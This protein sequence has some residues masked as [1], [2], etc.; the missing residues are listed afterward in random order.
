MQV[1]LIKRGAD[2]KTEVEAGK[3]Y[4]TEKPKVETK[5]KYVAEWHHKFIDKYIRSVIYK[6]KFTE[7]VKRK[8]AS[9][10][11]LDVE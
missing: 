5:I 10:K 8:Y 6:D 4:L 2:A 3:K 9:G 1:A 7:K 11:R